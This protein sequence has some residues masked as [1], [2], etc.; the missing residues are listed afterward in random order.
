MNSAKLLLYYRSRKDF[1]DIVGFSAEKHKLEV[2]YSGIIIDLFKGWQ[3]EKIGT[4]YQKLVVIGP[5]ILYLP[6]TNGCNLN[7]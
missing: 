1:C 2:N 7:D 6:L 3:V 4:G 5:I